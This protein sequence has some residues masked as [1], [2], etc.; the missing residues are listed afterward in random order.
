M[1]TEYLLPQDEGFLSGCSSPQP[2][3]K[4]V[5]FPRSI[6][7]DGLTHHFSTLS[8]NRYDVVQHVR[9]AADC[10]SPL[11]LFLRDP[12]VVEKLTKPSSSSSTTKKSR[13]PTRSPSPRRRNGGSSTTST[14]MTLVL[15][16]EERQAQ[17]LKTVLRTSSERLEYEMRRADDATSRAHAAEVR[18]ME[19]TSRATILEAARHQ[20]ELDLTRAAETIKRYQLQLETTERELKRVR[21]DFM[22]VDRERA[23][24]EALAAK[25]R[26]T[27]RSLQQSLRDCHAREDGRE[28]TSRLAMHKWFDEGREQG[29]DSGFEDGFAQGRK[30]GMSEGIKTGRKEGLREG[31]EQ[32]RIEERKNALEAFDRYVAEQEGDERTRRW[33]ASFYQI[34]DN[35][36]VGSLE[37]PSQRGHH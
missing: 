4:C 15:A 30:K 33:A 24:A 21:D 18:A 37:A 7:A 35:E 27:A 36:S 11:N 34:D 12:D 29:Y 1:P 14:L 23:D 25:A 6:L 19:A 13:P 9:D 20:L 26:D 8:I 31:R 28:E 3:F 5:L 16:E 2:S 22:R 17:H 32:G 10:P